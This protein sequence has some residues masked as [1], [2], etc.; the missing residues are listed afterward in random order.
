[1]QTTSPAPA[2]AA[3]G[4]QPPRGEGRA[5]VLGRPAAGAFVAPALLLIAGFLVFPARDQAL[6]AEV[7]LSS[8]V[9]EFPGG[10]RAIDRLDLRIEDGE[11]F[12]LLGP[13]GCGKTTLPRTI[14]GLEAPTSG[15]IKSAAAT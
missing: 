2:D 9:K 4:A 15:T 12:A 1:V 5:A 6:M 7:V 3:G 10:V 14:A 13:S 8:L 11:F